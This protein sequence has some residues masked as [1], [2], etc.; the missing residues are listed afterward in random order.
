MHTIT[1]D[2]AT[3]II[4]VDA[5]GFWTIARVEDFLRDLER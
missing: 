4:K 2:L 3:G 1:T 5:C